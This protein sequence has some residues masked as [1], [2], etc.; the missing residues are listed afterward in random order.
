MDVYIIFGVVAIL[1]VSLAEIISERKR[2]EAACI[3]HAQAAKRMLAEI[4]ALED[5][6]QK[7][8]G[9]DF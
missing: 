9:Y 6:A 8:V 2:N 1:I 5:K 7:M 3:L 4:N